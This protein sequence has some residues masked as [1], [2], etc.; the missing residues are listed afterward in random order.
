[1]HLLRNAVNPVQWG[2]R[3]QLLPS[4]SAQFGKSENYLPNQ[5]CKVLNF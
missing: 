5:N 2:E 3:Q 1:M 4:R